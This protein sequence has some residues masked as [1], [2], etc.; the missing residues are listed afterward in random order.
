[1]CM[2]LFSNFFALVLEFLD[3]FGFGIFR[4]KR[5]RKR[6]LLFFRCLVV[7]HMG[8][9]DSIIIMRKEALRWSHL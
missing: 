6:F 4:R 2:N 5:N 1:M 9:I 7:Q 8:M 3:E